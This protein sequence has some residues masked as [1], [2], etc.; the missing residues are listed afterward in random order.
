MSTTT[1]RGIDAASQ[2]RVQRESSGTF[3]ET[4]SC[5]SPYPEQRTAAAGISRSLAPRP[6]EFRAVHEGAPL[7]VI[8][9]MAPAFLLGELRIPSSFTSWGRNVK[10]QKGRDPGGT[11]DEKAQTEV[12]YR[13]E[14]T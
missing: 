7:E 9:L 4:R 5:H 14:N 2:N 10:T 1:W 3:A 13:G 8:D 6:S 11:N 12:P